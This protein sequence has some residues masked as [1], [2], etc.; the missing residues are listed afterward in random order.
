VRSQSESRLR[1]CPSFS[2]R[3]HP[4][5]AP[6][7]S[8]DSTSLCSYS[9]HSE[10]HCLCRVSV[11][12][13]DV[14]SISTMCMCMRGFEVRHAQTRRNDAHDM[15]PTMRPFTRLRS[16]H[17]THP[18]R[19]HCQYGPAWLVLDHLTASARCRAH[20]ASTQT[21]CPRRS[22][23]MHHH[24]HKAPIPLAQFHSR[25]AQNANATRMSHPHTMHT[26]TD[27]TVT[28]SFSLPHSPRL[29]HLHLHTHRARVTMKPSS[30][31]AA[32]AP[33]SG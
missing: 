20:M 26:P 8:P 7:R 1:K 32:V 19:K 15:H 2:I 25:N 4:I 22:R 28:D 33:P 16:H 27:H 29:L 31:T 10:T 30:S 21:P 3:I 11:C 5:S 13:C 14:C 18:P 9:R 23:T 24:S 17:A 6:S 12:V